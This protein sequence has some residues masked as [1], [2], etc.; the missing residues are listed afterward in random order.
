MYC[1]SG[2]ETSNWWTQYII[3]LIPRFSCIL[4]SSDVEAHI[5]NHSYICYI[6]QALRLS[7]RARQEKTVGELLN[8][9]SVDAQR[10]MDVMT[11]SHSVWSA[12][13]QIILALVF[14]WFT[15][16]SSIFVGVAVLIILIPI[17]TGLTAIQ[18]RYQVHAHNQPFSMSN[19]WEF[20]LLTLSTSD[21]SCITQLKYILHTCCRYNKWLKRM[22]VWS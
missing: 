18:K 8:L 21:Q 12:P 6:L 4:W 20:F 2:N 10:L 11:Y 22:N 14:L 13:L 16:G 3:S 17:N 9:M 7:S 1:R 15:M 19:Y 5:A